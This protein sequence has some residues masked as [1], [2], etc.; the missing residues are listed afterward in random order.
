MQQFSAIKLA[1]RLKE[2]GFDVRAEPSKL[3]SLVWELLG[4]PACGTGPDL[5]DPDGRYME[6]FCRNG[7]VVRKL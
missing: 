4:R 6:S 3:G 7:L 1:D 2:Q 5:F